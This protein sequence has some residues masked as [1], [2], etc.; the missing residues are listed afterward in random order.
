[1]GGRGRWSLA[2]L[3]AVWLAFGGLLIA[4]GTALAGN[5]AIMRTWQHTDAPVAAGKAGRTWMWGPA[6]T[7]EMNETATNAP[8]GTRTVRYF[9]KSRMEI[10]TDPAA[11][12]SSIWY[13]TNGLLAKELVTGQLQTGA[14]T[15]EP[16]K[17][18]QVNVAGDPDDTTGPTYASF[19]SHLADPP[20]AGGA[21]ITQRIDRAGVVHNDPAFANHGVTAAERLTVPGIDHQVASV[22]WE[23]MRSGGLV[24]ED[25]RYR[26]AA[27]FPNP[28]Y[29]T[30][31]PISEAY[32]ADVRVGNTPKVVLVQV[33]ERRVLTWTPDNAP[34]WRVEA[35]NVGSHYYQWRYGAAP[36]AGAPQIELPAVPD[37]P[38]MDDLEAEL[39]GMVNGWAGQN[40][41]S[42]TDLQ[43]GRTISVG[44]DRQ[45]PAACT[46]KVF[47]MVAIAEDISAGK[48]T[49]A[50]VEDLVQSAMGP[51]N[52]GPARELIRIAG[53]GDINAGIHR[54]NQIMQRVGMR[55]SILRHPPDYW[56]D[57]G[58]GDGDNYLTA[59]DMNRGL[60]AIWEGR[61]GLSDWGRDY[62][63]WSMTLAIPGQQYSL[64][65]P[66]PDDTVLY[67]KIGLVYAP[68]DTWND[69]GIVVFNRG[70]REY[71]YAISYLGSW[72]GNWLDAYY[73]GAEVS[74]VTWAAFSG[75]YR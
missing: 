5:D 48:Y 14:S 24:Y 42:V 56:G 38:F 51:S 26:D 62:V 69:A 52:T 45:Q 73:H 22:F 35:G 32:W 64:G 68:Y 7:D 34:G 50:D 74:A 1:M 27:L 37:S 60:E 8:G 41:V 49:T 47:I 40:A 54:I 29:A 65:G 46:I 28:Y 43:T 4:P 23:F 19:L 12:P 72:G 66:L 58:Y 2:V 44:G 3:L 39:H 15:F 25:G 10:A 11:D 63:L 31:Y 75:E 33:F 67:H 6:L 36:P 70:G 9:E 20:L 18:A 53:G 61:S 13:I 17:P 71:A 21:A 59:D 16:R 57:Y 30:G 55:D